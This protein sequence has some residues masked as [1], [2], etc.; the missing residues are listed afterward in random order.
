MSTAIFLVY[1]W[2]KTKT[3]D[4]VMTYFGAHREEASA[5]IGR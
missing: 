5:S 4:D 2:T 1:T 3:Q